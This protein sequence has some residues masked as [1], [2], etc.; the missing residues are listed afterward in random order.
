MATGFTK[1]HIEQQPKDVSSFISDYYIDELKR[2]I[3]DKHFFVAFLVISSGIEFLGKAI[4][5]RSWFKSG[6]S[7]MDFNNALNTFPSLKKYDNLGVKLDKAQK[8]VSFYS[9]VRCGILHASC[10]QKGITLSETVNNLPNEIGIIDLSR[11][12]FQACNDLLE[13]RVSLGKGKGL[14]DILCYY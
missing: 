7:K 3:R 11:D 1:T 5:D 2:L 14:S 12:F 4:S 10:P 6:T 8:D 9:V 13:K